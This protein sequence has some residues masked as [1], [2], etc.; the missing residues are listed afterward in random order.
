MPI[1]PYKCTECGHIE[2][3]LLEI[4]AR[5]KAQSC[6]HCGALMRRAIEL[7]NVVM[8]PDIEA[9][10]D[11]SLGEYIGSRR[12]LREKLAFANAYCPDLMQNSEPQAGRLTK[13]ERAIAEGRPVYQKKTIFERRQEPG[14]GKEPDIGSALAGKDPDAGDG[15][16]TTEGV[17]DYKEIKDYIKERS[18]AARRS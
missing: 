13:E 15:L 9:G 18:N 5:N 7:Q 17:A 14:W 11:E 10:F 4:N 3:D 16:I 12:E 6:P 2:E 8:R 1:Y